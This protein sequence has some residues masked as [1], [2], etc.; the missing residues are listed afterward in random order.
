MNRSVNLGSRPSSP[1]KI[2]FFT[3]AFRKP[4]W[5]RSRRHVMRNGHVNSE[6]K[7]RRKPAAKLRKEPRNANPAPGP[8]YIIIGVFLLRTELAKPSRDKW[9][10]GRNTRLLQTVPRGRR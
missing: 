1:R 10:R 7:L 2:T 6:K 9:A 3:R 4:W 5:R 8:T